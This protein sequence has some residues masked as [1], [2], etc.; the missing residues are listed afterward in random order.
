MTSFHWLLFIL[1]VQ[2]IHFLGTWKL[3][4]AAGRKSW[5]AA[6]PVYNAIVLMKI[7]NRPSWWTLLLFIPIVN[8][9]M[10]PVVW[11]ETIRS[12]GKNAALD[13]FLVIATFGFYI[14]YI[15]YTQKLN[16]IADRSLTP[17][18]KTADTISSLLFAIVVATIVHGYVIQPFNIPSSSLEKSLLIGDFLFVSKF[19]YGARPPMTA[20]AAPMV[21]DTL[22]LLNKKSYLNWPQLPY[23]RLPGFQ[24]IKN[25]DIVVFNWPRDTLYNMYLPADK[26]Y[27][28]P[29]DKKTNY[30]KRC[31]G[32]PGDSL[33]IKN[34]IVFINGKELILPE[35]AKPQYSYKI[36]NDGK[37]SI[38]F[39]TLLESLNVTEQAG[40]SDNIKR[41]TL[42]VRALTFEA[43]E[44]LKNTPGIT[45]VER[46]INKGPE[47][48]IFPD[49]KDG[50]PSVNN[51]WSCDNYGPIYIPE[52]GKTVAL[53]TTSLPFYKIII[54]E[55][56]GNKLSVVG[57]DIY[58]NDQKATTYTFKQNYYWM[59]G[60]NRHNSLDA[61]YF[62]YTPENHVVGKPVFIWLSLDPN[63]KGLSKIRWERVFTTVSG[64]GQP[65]SYFRYFLIFL[66]LYFGIEYFV[67][68]RKKTEA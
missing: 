26:R 47:D 36:A 24:K 17:K 40:F 4:V 60:D 27:D 53:N 50:K 43:A 19:H 7:I 13:T 10:F 35:R 66:A 32:I 22:P 59:M 31:V 45:A 68:K 5:E 16:Y 11:V 55:Y 23:L 54:T 28:K 1:I 6:I 46:I 57:N 67:K 51:N 37:T 3:Y 21:H 33:S 62:G 44:K 2:V 14:Y 64:E 61:R 30:V 15:N 49:F 9:I 58:V 34:G 41:D 52:A 48:G 25:N 56:E 63:K 12:F 18:N 42:Y 39:G 38:D 8:L 65:Q 20:V 29:V